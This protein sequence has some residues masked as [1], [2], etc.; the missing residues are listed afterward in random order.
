LPQLEGINCKCVS[1]QRLVNQ[2]GDKLGCELESAIEYWSAH[3]G[4]I[5]RKVEITVLMASRNGEHVLPR[6]LGGYR[7][8]AVPS[9][10]WKIVIVD[11]GSTDS[12]SKI[13]DS[14]KRHLP[15][16]VLQQS[17]PGKNRALNT[18]LAAVEGRLVVVTDD[19]AIPHPSLLTA[20]EKVL[21]TK[22]DYGLFGGSIEPLFELPPPKWLVESKLHFALM[23]SQRD[24]PEG[25]INAG[26]IYGP[27]MAIRASI[28][29]R[30]FRF[31]ENIGPNACDSDYPMGGESEF[32]HR[33]ASSRV[34]CWFASEARVSHLVRPA[35]LT[36]PAWAKRAY[37][38]GRGRAHQMWQRGEIF[39]A[40]TPSWIDWLATLSPI[41]KHRMRSMCARH[42]A[43]GFRDECAR[44][45][46]STSG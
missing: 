31:D 42:L 6:T 39:A 40:P 23:F 28:F 13:I 1:I 36:R 46:S 15:I 38:C 44:R 45:L 5:M 32:C 29:D 20:W 41:T 19:D 9:V 14:Y 35:Q 24:L 25:P 43:R 2:S 10:G 21:D 7:E 4:E 11:N 30:G 3:I 27:N 22:Q 12:T 26:D 34:K 16:E 33:V 18:G 8:T 17:L 37:R